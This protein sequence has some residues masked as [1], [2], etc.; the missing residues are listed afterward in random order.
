MAAA[1]R[2]MPIAP[3][4]RPESGARR[5]K[6]TMRIRDTRFGIVMVNR[7]E[8]AAIARQNGSITKTAVAIMR[9]PRS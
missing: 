4:A 7:S 9:I 1:A 3:K 8:N 2:C 5:K 6:E